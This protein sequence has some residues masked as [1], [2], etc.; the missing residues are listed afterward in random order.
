MKYMAKIDWVKVK[1][2][3]REKVPEGKYCILAKLLNASRNLFGFSVG[4]YWSLW[5]QPLTQSRKQRK[6]KWQFAVVWFLMPDAP[7]ILLYQGANFELWE[8][9][10]VANGE[11]LYEYKGELP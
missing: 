1:D 11:I 10:V 7:D 8:D 6:Q 4:E 2:G 5:V 9:R 3:G